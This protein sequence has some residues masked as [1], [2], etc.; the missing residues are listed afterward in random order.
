MALGMKAEALGREP[1]KLT[2]VASHHRGDPGKLTRKARKILEL[3]GKLRK[4]PR[5][6]GAFLSTPLSLSTRPCG[7]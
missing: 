1:R 4:E 3:S 2:G 6:S 5:H 7:S